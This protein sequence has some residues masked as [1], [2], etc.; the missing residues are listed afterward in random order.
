MPFEHATWLAEDIQRLSQHHSPCLLL[1]DAFEVAAEAMAQ[2]LARHALCLQEALPDCDCVSCRWGLTQHPDCFMLNANHNLDDLRAAAQRWVHT[3]SIS[4]CRVVVL[5]NV[6]DYSERVLNALLKNLEEPAPQLRFILTAR[7]R[8]GVKSTIRSRAHAYPLR[9]PSADE[10]LQ[11]VMKRRKIARQVAQSLLAQHQANPYRAAS[12]DDVLRDEE[13]FLR[14]LPGFV[15]KRYSALF[16]YL[17]ALGA[18][19]LD[20]LLQ[21]LAQLIYWKQFD[22]KPA[23]WHNF[24]LDEAVWAALNPVDL[25]HLYARLQ[26]LRRPEIM[27]THRLIQIKALLS[28]EQRNIT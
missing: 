12:A 20:G 15:E 23:H 27:Q 14:C 5:L 1:L 24:H 2:R 16:H 3:P 18:D 13:A 22:I 28:T 11:Y 17:E 8:Q 19:A 7:Q 6:D 26:A 4:P 9:Q 10:A 25:H 21:Q